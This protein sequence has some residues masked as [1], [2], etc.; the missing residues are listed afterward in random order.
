MTILSCKGKIFCKIIH[1]TVHKDTDYRK[2]ALT[3]IKFKNF[4]AEDVENVMQEEISKN[5]FRIKEEVLQIV[6]SKLTKLKDDP[7]FKD[8]IKF[9]Y[10]L[11][12]K[13]KITKIVFGFSY[14]CLSKII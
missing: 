12:K 14:Y 3:K 11:R 10:N 2:N 4:I 13:P 5:Y 8:L 1:I 6:C 9:Q 7:K